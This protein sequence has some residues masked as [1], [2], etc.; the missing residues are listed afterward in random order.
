M[1]IT[2]YFSVAE[3]AA[4]LGVS[5]ATISESIKA[6]RVRAFSLLQETVIA[7]RDIQKLALDKPEPVGA[8]N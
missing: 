8:E 2:T 5:E 6:G 7:D 1:Q 4:M 3:V